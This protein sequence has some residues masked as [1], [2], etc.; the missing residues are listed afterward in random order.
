VGHLGKECSEGQQNPA[1]HFECPISE[2]EGSVFILVHFRKQAF[3]SSVLGA[4]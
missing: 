4:V 1:E 3:M 2:A